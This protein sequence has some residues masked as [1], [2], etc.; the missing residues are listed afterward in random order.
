MVLKSVGILSAAKVSGALTA[1][2]GLIAGG[3]MAVI[4]L[5]GVAVKAQQNGPPFPAMFLGLGAVILVPIFYGVM[6][7]IMGALYAAIYNFFA[8]IVGG[9]EF[10]FEYSPTT[11]NA[12]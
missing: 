5:M 9:I 7:F 2:L 1:I 8:G 4:S 12:P 3:M 6:G 10:E 11:S